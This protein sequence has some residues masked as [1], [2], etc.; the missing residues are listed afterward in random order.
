MIQ[1]DTYT[2]LQ[3]IFSQPYNSA[4]SQCLAQTGTSMTNTQ[5]MNSIRMSLNAKLKFGIGIRSLRIL[6]FLLMF[7]IPRFFL[8][9]LRKT[10]MANNM[11]GKFS[12]KLCL[13]APSRFI[14]QWTYFFTMFLISVRKHMPY[15]SSSP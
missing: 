7:C 9:A 4:S 1:G 8:Y 15:S 6:R 2:V 13:I 14:C 12:V 10:N 3:S 11:A 5:W